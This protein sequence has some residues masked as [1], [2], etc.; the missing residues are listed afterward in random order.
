MT[1]LGFVAY[2]AYEFNLRR[3]AGVQHVAHFYHFLSAADGV[4]HNVVHRKVYM[5]PKL[6]A[7]ADKVK[8]PNGLRMGLDGSAGA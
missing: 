5:R 3:I 2:R 6:S 4:F 8:G 7:N 1:C